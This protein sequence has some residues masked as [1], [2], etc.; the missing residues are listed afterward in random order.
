MSLSRGICHVI[1]VYLSPKKFFSHFGPT[2]VSG[3]FLTGWIY[4]FLNIFIGLLRKYLKNT[5]YFNDGFSGDKNATLCL[6]SH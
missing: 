3:N 2:M 5:L 1:F 6:P 4:L